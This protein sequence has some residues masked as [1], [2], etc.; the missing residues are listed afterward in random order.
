[1]L[2]SKLIEL[3]KSRGLTQDELAT[4]L[5]ISRS[6]VAKYETNKAYPTNEVMQRIANYFEI[7]IDEL[8]TKEE[9]IDKQSKVSD[10]E[11]SKNKIIAILISIIGILIVSIVAIMWEID[12]D[13]IETEVDM[14]AL[15]YDAE[16]ARFDLIYFE[17]S[18]PNIWHRK[19]HLYIS[20]FQ[21]SAPDDTTQFTIEGED[22]FVQFNKYNISEDYKEF[23]TATLYYHVTVRKNLFGIVKGKGYYLEKVD[24]HLE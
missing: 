12:V 24:F 23:K 10:N 21:P 5:F 13:T 14:A 11:R 18:N 7:S 2:S 22:F 19:Q 8:T 4:K 15:S 9:L 6:M 20:E 1:M 16:H 3:R 17:E